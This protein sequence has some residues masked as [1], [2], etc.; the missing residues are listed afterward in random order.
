MSLTLDEARERA[1]TLSGVSYD[2]AL[3]LTDEH[4]FGSRTTVRFDTDAAET[5]LELTDATDLR[6]RVDGM[7]VAEPQYDGRRLRLAGLDRS[8]EVVVEA[9]L[10]YVTDG[11]GMH[12][13]TDP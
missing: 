11:A 9:R 2:V 13:M 12:T 6:L 8:A 10:P 5:F 3:D 4:S 1:R 7:P